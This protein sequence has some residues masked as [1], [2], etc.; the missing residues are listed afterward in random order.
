M[1]DLQ[2]Q[3]GNIIDY[4][5]L[6]ANSTPVILIIYSNDETWAGRYAAEGKIVCIFV[7][8]NYIHVIQLM[9]WLYHQKHLKLQIIDLVMDMVAC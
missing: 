6:D 8:I 7:F 5:F 1:I 3:C 9:I 4:L 2:Y